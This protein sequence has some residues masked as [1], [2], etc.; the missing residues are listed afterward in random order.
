M[1]QSASSGILLALSLIPYAAVSWAY[2]AFVDGGWPDFWKCFG[3]LSVVRV[4]FSV[5]EGMGGILVWRIYGRRVAVAHWLKYFRE[6]KFPPKEY[7][8]DDFGNYRA[9]LMS[10]YKRPVDVPFLASEIDSWLASCEQ[11]GI[12]LGMRMNAAVEEAF[13]RY[14]ATQPPAAKAGP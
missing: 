2:A 1:D 9:R 10:V 5:I 4:F 13:R 12:L 3:L 14:Q 8:S 11:R 7:A 6:N